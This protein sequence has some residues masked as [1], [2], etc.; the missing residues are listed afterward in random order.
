MSNSLGGINIVLCKRITD[1][2]NLLSVSYE[3][4]NTYT[5][6][7]LLEQK[8]LREHRLIGCFHSLYVTFSTFPTSFSIT[9]LAFLSIT[10][11]VF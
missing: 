4:E 5:S 6:G 11:A 7:S 10:N 3:T 9:L 8:L 1:L 2:V